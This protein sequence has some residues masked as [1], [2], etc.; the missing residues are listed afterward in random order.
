MRSPWD[1]IL[2]PHALKE[3][4]WYL[5]FFTPPQGHQFEPRVKT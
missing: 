2:N 1:A 4:I 5:T 3:I